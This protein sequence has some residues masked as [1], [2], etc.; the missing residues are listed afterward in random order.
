MDL[1][2]AGRKRSE[3]EEEKHLRLDVHVVAIPHLHHVDDGFEDDDLQRLFGGFPL[4]LGHVCAA[5]V[6][7]VGPDEVLVEAIPG[8]GATDILV[9][10]GHQRQAAVPP[11]FAIRGV[12]A[13]VG[14]L[15]FVCEAGSAPDLL[16]R[17][18]DSEGDGELTE[19]L[20][21]PCRL[22]QMFQGRE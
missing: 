12:G 1:H 7:G 15:N 8:G 19:D 5:Q 22:S 21:Y 17:L 11:G 6:F 14:G 3:K 10:R 20:H 18:P 13:F 2:S 9:L 4:L 16:G